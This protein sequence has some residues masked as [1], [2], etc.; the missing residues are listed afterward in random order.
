MYAYDD[1]I[2]L[3]T[4]DC[5]V[6]LLVAP[7]SHRSEHYLKRHNTALHKIYSASPS[8]TKYTDMLFDVIDIA[9]LRLPLVEFMDNQLTIYHPHLQSV[10]LDDH[11]YQKCTSVIQRLQNSNVIVD[12][13]MLSIDGESKSTESD[14]VKAT[15]VSECIQTDKRSYAEILS[16]LPPLSTIQKVSVLWELRIKR[17]MRD[18][19]M[20]QKLLRLLYQSVYIGLN[21]YPAGTILYNFF[22]E[23]IDMMKDFLLLLKLGPEHALD[24]P[25][26][27]SITL[28][29]DIYTLSLL[30]LEAT[31]DVKDFTVPSIF[32]RFPWLLYELGVSKGQYMGLLPSVLRKYCNAIQHDKESSTTTESLSLK[33]FEQVLIFVMALLNS[34]ASCLTVLIDNGLISL[35]LGTIQSPIADADIVLTNFHAALYTATDSLLDV[36]TLMYEILEHAVIQHS[37]GSNAFKEH[38]GVNTVYTALLYELSAY[39]GVGKRVDTQ[40]NILIEE[41]FSLLL[42]YI[43]EGRPDPADQSLQLFYRSKA[44]IVLFHTVF[45]YHALFST[46]VLMASLSLIVEIMNRDAM[47]PTIVNYILQARDNFQISVLDELLSTVEAANKV[48]DTFLLKNDL[49]ILHVSFISAISIT[50]AGTTY[51]ASVRYIEKVLSVLSCPH[52][53]LPSSRICM[54]QELICS[55]GASVEELIRH[56]PIYMNAVVDFLL[57]RVSSLSNKLKEII[58]ANDTRIGE[59]NQVLLHYYYLQ[60]YLTLFEFLLVKT[61]VINYF[62]TQ[63]GF[64]IIGGLLPLVMGSSRYRI[65][66]LSTLLDNTIHLMGHTPLRHLILHIFS[67][68]VENNGDNKTILRSLFD[69]LSLQVNSEVDVLKEK[70]LEYNTIYN[71][72][73]AIEGAK[74][75]LFSN[76][77]E[78]LSRDP[79]HNYIS[80]DTPLSLQLLAV[81]EIAK[82]VI[83]LDLYIDS[84]GLLV[85]PLKTSHLT[86]S[87]RPVFNCLQDSAMVKQAAYTIGMLLEEVF[88]PLEMEMARAKGSFVNTDNIDA[89]V[90][91]NQMDVEAEVTP[92]PVSSFV[93]VH[94]VY[95]LLI[96][97]DTVVVRETIDDSSKKVLKLQKGSI[98]K[99]Y[100]RKL[101]PNNIL[102]YR[103]DYGWI[104]IFKNANHLFDAQ[105]LVINV[106]SKP[107]ELVKAES[108]AA[109]QTVY[110]TYKDKLDYE[111]LA[112]IS[113]RRAGFLLFFHMFHTVKVNVF[114][115][116]TRLCMSKEIYIDGN[117]GRYHAPDPQLV[118]AYSHIRQLG[119]RLMPVVLNVFETIIKESNLSHPAQESWDTDRE[120]YNMAQAISSALPTAASANSLAGDML[121]ETS[122]IG[123]ASASANSTLFQQLETEYFKSNSYLISEGKGISSCFIPTLSQFSTQKCYHVI[124]LMELFQTCFFDLSS[125]LMVGRRSSSN[126]KSEINYLFFAYLLN[127][128]YVHILKTMVANFVSAYMCAFDPFAFPEDLKRFVTEDNVI[129]P[130]R[131]ELVTDN[132]TDLDAYKALILYNAE[133]PEIVKAYIHYRNRI[134]ERRSLMLTNLDIVLDMIKTLY[135]GLNS[136]P[137]S[138]EKNMYV[139]LVQQ[140]NDTLPNDSTGSSGS[141]CS[142]SDAVIPYYDPYLLRKKSVMIMT[143]YIACF[144]TTLDPYLFHLH[145]HHSKLIFELLTSVIK[146]FQEMKLTQARITSSSLTRQRPVHMPPG[147]L[148][149]SG[150]RIPRMPS[151]FSP[152][153]MGHLED[154]LLA[155][156]YA[157]GPG[158]GRLTHLGSSSVLDPAGNRVAATFT[159]QENIITSLMEMGFDRTLVTRTMN[160]LRSNDMETLVAFLLE[161]VYMLEELERTQARSGAQSVAAAGAAISSSSSSVR[162]SASVMSSTPTAAESAPAASV[163]PSNSSSTIVPPPAEL[164][165]MAPPAPAVLS[166]FLLPVMVKRSEDDIKKMRDFGNKVLL[167]L[168]N[169]AILMFLHS[170]QFGN[171][172][173]HMITSGDEDSPLSSVGSGQNG[174]L[175]VYDMDLPLS[176]KFKRETFTMAILNTMLKVF[177]KVQASEGVVRLIQLQWL[178]THLISI[179]DSHGKYSARY[180]NYSLQGLLHAI[181]ILLYSKISPS[182]GVSMPQRVSAVS[183]CEL[184]YLVFAYDNRFNSF[185]D[186][187]FVYMEAAVVQSA[188]VG[189]SISVV[190]WLTSALLLLDTLSHHILL[191]QDSLRSSLK[192]VDNIHKFN[193]GLY[194]ELSALQCTPDILLAANVRSEIMRVI[195]STDESTSALS[196]TRNLL[197]RL[198]RAIGGRSNVPSAA[199]SPITALEAK[200][201]TITKEPTASAPTSS[202]AVLPFFEG[203]LSLSQKKLFIRVIVRILQ[204]QTGKDEGSIKQAVQ[205]NQACYQ[206]LLH[207]LTTDELR[208]EFIL[209]K[210]PVQ[211]LKNQTLLFD[212]YLLSLYSLLQRCLEDD[213]YVY[214]NMVNTIKIIYLRLQKQAQF[215]SPIYLKNLIE[216]C[217]ALVQRDSRMFLRAVDEL[218]DIKPDSNTPMQLTVLL[219]AAEGAKMDGNAPVES[220]VLHNRDVSSTAQQEGDEVGKD[221]ESSGVKRRKLN[222]SSSIAVGNMAAI[223]SPGNNPHSVRSRGNSLVKSKQRTQLSLEITIEICTAIYRLFMVASYVHAHPSVALNETKGAAGSMISLS[224][225]LVLLADLFSSMPFLLLTLQKLQFTTQ[226]QDQ[227]SINVNNIQFIGLEESLGCESLHESLKTRSPVTS[228]MSFITFLVQIIHPFSYSMMASDKTWE[229]SHSMLNGGGKLVP[230]VG[231]IKKLIGDNVF[232]NSCYLL[233]A[234]L[235]RVNS[236]RCGILQSLVSAAI[237]TGSGD[238]SKLSCFADTVSKL[239]NPPKSWISRDTF[240]YLL[241]DIMVSLLSLGYPV[242]IVNLINSIDVSKQGGQVAL[243]ALSNA[244]EM[245]YR[246]GS[247]VVSK[248]AYNP[249]ISDDTSSSMSGAE[250][251]VARATDPSPTS[252]VQGNEESMLTY[253]NNFML[254]SNNTHTEHI[255][256]DEDEDINMIA[257]GLDEDR[258][259]SINNS[260]EEEQDDEGSQ[261]DVT[262]EEEEEGDIDDSSDDSDEI[263][264]NHTHDHEHHDEDSDEQDGEGENHSDSEDDHEQSDH[265]GDN[266]EDDDDDDDHGNRWNHG[267]RHD[268]EDEMDEDEHQPSEGDES[269]NDDEQSDDQADV[270]DDLGATGWG[271]VGGGVGPG[272]AFSPVGDNEHA[273]GD[274]MAN[275]F[276]QMLEEM[277]DEINEDNE[278][279]ELDADDEPQSDLQD[280]LAQS[281]SNAGLEEDEYSAQEQ[282]LQSLLPSSSSMRMVPRSSGYRNLHHGHGHG[283]GGRSRRMSHGFMSG[284]ELSDMLPVP[285]SVIQDI[286]RHSNALMRSSGGNH[287]NGGGHNMLMNNFQ[288]LMSS[289]IP[290]GAISSASFAR[291][292]ANSG[293][294]TLSFSRDAARSGLN[295]LARRTGS[296]AS[297]ANIQ[298]LAPSMHPLLAT[299]NESN[300][301]ARRSSILAAMSAPTIGGRAPGLGNLMFNPIGAQLTSSVSSSYVVNDTGRMSRGAN[302]ARRRAMGPIVSDRRWGVDIAENDNFNLRVG[303][304]TNNI[305]R[306][307]QQKGNLVESS[308][309]STGKRG[310]LFDLDYPSPTSHAMH[311]DESKEEGEL[312]ETKEDVGD[313]VA[314]RGAARNT[315]LRGDEDL[316]LRLGRGP[317]IPPSGGNRSNFASSSSIPPSMLAQLGMPRNSNTSG[318]LLTFSDI[319]N[320][321]QSTLNTMNPPARNSGTSSNGTG[322]VISTAI[323]QPTQAVLPADPI[324]PELSTAS[325]LSN[326]S[327]PAPGTAPVAAGAPDGHHSD[328]DDDDEGGHS[329]EER[330]GEEEDGSQENEEWEDIDDDVDS[331][332]EEGNGQDEDHME[333]DEEQEEQEQHQEGEPMALQDGPAEGNGLAGTIIADPSMYSE[334]NVDFIAT[335]PP[336]LRQEVLLNSEDNFLI[337]LPQELIDEALQYREAQL[338][339]MQFANYTNQSEAPV[340]TPALVNLSV[341]PASTSLIAPV[342]ASQLVSS[343]GT[344]V[345]AAVVG[346]PAPVAS[347]LS[348]VP[349][350]RTDSIS[351]AV[352]V[353]EQCDGLS[354]LQEIQK[355]I[356]TPF[357]QRLPEYST[358]V[359]NLKIKLSNPGT[360]STVTADLPTINVKDYDSAVSVAHP[361]MYNTMFLTRIMSSIFDVSRLKVPKSL[362]KLLVVMMK[363]MTSRKPLVS[364]ML[365]VLQGQSI[366]INNCLQLC[367]SQIDNKSHS[368]LKKYALKDLQQEMHQFLPAI[369]PPSGQIN[370]YWLRKFLSLFIYLLKKTDNLVWYTFMEYSMEKTSMLFDSTVQTSHDL[371]LCAANATLM[372]KHTLY[373]MYQTDSTPIKHHTTFFFVFCSMISH[374]LPT[375][376]TSDVETCLQVI[377]EMSMQYGKCNVQQA[378]Q[379]YYHTVRRLADSGTVPTLSTTTMTTS[380]SMEFSKDK[381]HDANDSAAEDHPVGCLL[382][383]IS[384]SNAKTLPFV[385]L[386]EQD[387]QFYVNLMLHIDL[388]TSSKKRLM[389][390]MRHLSLCNNNWHVVLIHCVYLA[391]KLVESCVE[392]YQQ[393]YIKLCEASQNPSLCA[394]MQLKTNSLVETR[395]LTALKM[396]TILRARSSSVAQTESL[397]IAHYMMH[398]QCHSLW[399]ILLKCLDHVRVIEEHHHASH[400]HAQPQV[401]AAAQPNALS[402]KHISSY[403]MQYIPLIE[404]FLSYIG[405]TLCLKNAYTTQETANVS[406]ASIMSV[407]GGGDESGSMDNTNTFQG[408]LQ[409][410]QQTLQ[411]NSTYLTTFAEHNQN[412]LNIILKS[413]IHLLESSFAPLIVHPVCRNVLHFDIKRIYFKNKLKKLKQTSQ[414][415]SGGGYLRLHVRRE[416]VFEESFQ[417]LRYKTASEMRRRLSVMFH[418]EEGIVCISC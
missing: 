239:L 35:F 305:E 396:M 260:Q 208:T 190:Q 371:Q 248:I 131:Y 132:I 259:E 115:N 143:R 286:Q 189:A 113:L 128:K 104:S 407:C 352:E 52:Y 297:D 211:L 112:N 228:T 268:H 178:S 15:V 141:G 207:L 138:Y 403:T 193:P 49:S 58:S 226:E 227:Y 387:M 92:S 17:L 101:V 137:T 368:A 71:Q 33:W 347:T 378:N 129:L 220:S 272:I 230:A 219:K 231:V 258:A 140:N 198:S 45:R 381:A 325:A 366:V 136:T 142:S 195:G 270:M 105:F 169:K 37:A 149:G 170:I 44:F 414:G 344:N 97:A 116:V 310:G 22:T 309:P 276:D 146:V 5:L 254:L 262:I 181:V 411:T 367:L 412:L 388:S 174:S 383:Q 171:S 405:T 88:I 134:R 398:I 21:C 343:A 233:G 273:D 369:H 23:K 302:H 110:R 192:E 251:S 241:Q 194:S 285:I 197:G 313:I 39:T 294:V 95:E 186:K 217:C 79:I 107:L 397:V 392:Q 50:E 417:A 280:M 166:H 172:Y 253:D 240:I 204:L 245:I 292:D 188:A 335:L 395:L 232:N 62:V 66:F 94:P 73:P 256:D 242:H 314:P 229:I 179:L 26:S 238:L 114:M 306:Y 4:L 224:D 365:S 328:G 125:M 69:Y 356:R 334:D 182:S 376:T 167:Y 124:R 150:P 156:A 216:I 100:E 300:T 246:K 38:E 243:T 237:E 337:T 55:L 290:E 362:L 8:L 349:L 176:T 180:V 377:E 155:D 326:A 331:E 394:N 127:D 218:F 111:K 263:E 360:S 277:Q 196:N 351:A 247:S 312:Q 51:V 327:Q 152:H 109:E 122:T 12:Q 293:T 117:M 249:S 25:N 133:Q 41:M 139:R 210:G 374:Y 213:E 209:L 301:A 120:L 329:D 102:K 336:E 40:G 2:V 30:C 68:C 84:W 391:N 108:Q 65:Q 13:T 154:M 20:K 99:S 318:T 32:L 364:L 295:N 75:M 164:A 282:N 206:F 16:T 64:E 29:F 96:V 98:V 163:G 161:N 153:D 236:L 89:E 363:D 223:S 47:P 187:L 257:D 106:Y 61:P 372:S 281:P 317:M 370:V 307:L 90:D 379:V 323:S 332:E 319:L 48:E 296:R 86:T 346:S 184:H 322:A 235:S 53:Y 183:A 274:N 199:D 118:D 402:S 74:H 271:A 87:Y 252:H 354:V 1:D 348:S 415:Q 418:N 416:H 267:N 202:S 338:L 121:S 324:Q 375:L 380:R 255:S 28:D 385:I 34:P 31:L 19:T 320:R 10:L 159:P 54:N 147:A 212:N 76:F 18:Y 83:L 200:P 145:A 14:T 298:G 91:G 315:S 81:S 399:D 409:Q 158:S 173:K 201:E 303:A 85:G 401:Q 103:T 279:N 162:A 56:F 278:G 24:V 283:G 389:R 77:L 308:R 410:I 57:E 225:Y 353:K 148:V 43:Q 46:S 266:D 265:G 9:Y 386:S 175:T 203:C 373:N 304:L 390:V 214:A 205:L 358:N 123:E 67:L 63:N 191:D 287:N 6:A 289:I 72:H 384:K 130:N 222:D 168:Y 291:V 361:L 321:F 135:S 185:S 70:M 234:L 78:T 3:A 311:Y 165:A 160:A 177:E 393:N 382:A 404:C 157:G 284:H 144:W 288:D 413:N 261:G 330:E 221:V 60:S 316:Q 119:V 340:A 27:Q 36:Y 250:N 355:Y 275:D 244:L 269:V 11:V 299:P 93:R 264:H 82:H 342:A 7:L 151:S 341:A 59:N 333:A 42:S 126:S 357:D 80:E 408:S 215:I 400:G 406:L 339:S 345:A 350:V 359:K